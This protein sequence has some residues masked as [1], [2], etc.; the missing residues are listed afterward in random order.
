MSVA[1]ATWNLDCVRPGHGPKSARIRETLAHVKPDVWV[2]TE[3]HPEFAPGAGYDRI[4]VSAP[5]PDRERGG[6][7]VAI[8]VRQGLPATALELVGEPERTA[9]VRIH[10][11]ESRP[12]VVFGTVLPWRRDDRHA[13]YRGGRAFE[14][15]LAAQVKDWDR[16]IAM[17]PPVGLC[18]AG[19]FNQELPVEGPAGTRAGRLALE[20]A[21][22][23][24]SLR[25]V[26]GGADD[27]LKARG[28][29]E[30]IDHVVLSQGL[31][32]TTAMPAIW[33]EQF[34]LPQNLSDHYGLCV[35]LADA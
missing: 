32:T 3:S 12:L 34:P 14:R 30:N 22:L 35:Q 5:A 31:R 25:C 4:A 2:L 23:Q 33:P 7:W 27:P 8:W 17:D 1:V 29:G 15:A 24:R 9:A 11:G 20:Q 28:W 10:F 13:G 16:A 6:V 26:T 19:D 21:L 18:I